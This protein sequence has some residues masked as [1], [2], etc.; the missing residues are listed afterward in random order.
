MRY[1][2]PD[3]TNIV[4]MRRL[5]FVL[6]WLLVAFAATGVAW[7]ALSS[8][9]RQVG[10]VPLTPA[11]NVSADRPDV[12]ETSTSFPD[13]TT[14]APAVPTS[15][16]ARSVTTVSPA[17]SSSSSTSPSQSTTSSTRATTSTTNV[18]TSTTNVPTSTTTTNA[19]PE[20]DKTTV[21]SKGGVVVV[22]HRTDQV[23]LES[24]TPNPGFSMEIRDTGPDEVRVEF[25]QVEESY[26]VRVRW[27]EGELDIQVSEDH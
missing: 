24:A 6:A 17:P 5:G 7:A 3:P 16:A 8:A 18:P 14:T 19:P 26:E 1:R 15:L 12:D 4:A 22:G 21:P 20:W 10:E 2:Y 13:S 25:S 27:D 9:D 11:L 23:R